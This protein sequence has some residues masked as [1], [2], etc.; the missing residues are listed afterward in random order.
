MLTSFSHLGIFINTKK[1]INENEI[2]EW[3]SKHGPQQ[4]SIWSVGWYKMQV[5]F[6][7]Y[8]HLKDQGIMMFT[9]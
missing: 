8:L 4:P 2:N 5:V 6:L 3:F 7:T 9:V 1:R